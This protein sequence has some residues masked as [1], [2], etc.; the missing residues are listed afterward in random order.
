MYGIILSFKLKFFFF[1][2]FATKDLAEHI[3]INAVY[4]GVPLENH[5]QISVTN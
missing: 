4:Y 3:Q 5:Q 2:H 1:R